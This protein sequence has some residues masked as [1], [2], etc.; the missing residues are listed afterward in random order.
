MAGVVPSEKG[1][2]ATKSSSQSQNF[3]QDHLLCW[4]HFALATF[5]SKTEHSDTAALQ[6]LWAR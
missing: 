4:W 2:A 5:A 1:E 3:L 6:Y